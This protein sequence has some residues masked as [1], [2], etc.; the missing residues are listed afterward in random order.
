MKRIALCAAVM[1]C[2]VQQIQADEPPSWIDALTVTPPNEAGVGSITLSGEWLDTC[3]PDTEFHEVEESRIDIIVEHP[4]INVGCGD[5][6]TPWSLTESI[7]PLPPRTYSIYATLYEV[8]PNNSSLRELVQGPDLL[9]TD[10]VVAEP[11][12]LALL[13]TAFLTIT[14]AWWRRKR[15]TTEWRHS[16]RPGG[17][18]RGKPSRRRTAV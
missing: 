17:Q 10:Y 6:I 15:A 16:E 5:A 11:S 9:V 18:A 1:L 12:A 14:T 4:G 3:T 13:T 2:G 7:G 8:D